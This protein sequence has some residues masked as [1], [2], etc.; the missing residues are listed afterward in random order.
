MSQVP[1]GVEGKSAERKGKDI[2]SSICKLKGNLR[3]ITGNKKVDG[4]AEIKKRRRK[5]Y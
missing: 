4:L 1:G 3:I 2:S 5:A